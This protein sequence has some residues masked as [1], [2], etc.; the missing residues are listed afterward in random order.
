MGGMMKNRWNVAIAAAVACVLTALLAIASQAAWADELSDLRANQELLQRRV[1]QLAQ[2]T[3]VPATGIGAGGLTSGS[4]PRSFLIPGTDTSL[5]VGGEINLTGVYWFTGG[6]NSNAGGG[7]QILGVPG[8]STAPLNFSIPGVLNP[9]RTR[10]N[11]VFDYSIYA[12][13]LHVE[14]RTPTYLGEAQTVFE[15]DFLGCSLGGFDCNNTVAGQDGLGVRLRLAYATLGQFIAG[16]AWI[17]SI[18]LAA[19]PETIDTGCCA[20]E[21]STGRQPQVAWVQPLQPWGMP[22]ASFGISLASPEDSAMT[23]QGQ[24]LTS[25]TN[26]VT[27]AGTTS[28]TSNAGTVL[29]AGSNQAL[30]IN[31][32][33]T[34]MPD[35]AGN[36]KFVQPWGH[37]QFSGVVHQ[38][39]L[40]DGS[41]LNRQYIGFGGGFSG[42]VKPGWFGWAKDDFG[43]NAF[44]G[45]GLGRY[46]GGGGSGNY[47]PYLETNYGAIG[48]T[49][50]TPSALG[51]ATGNVCGYGHAGVTSTAA[52]ASDI[53]ARLLPEFGAEAW[54]QHWWT[55]TLRSTL[56]FG[57]VHQ[58]PNTRIVG[59][60]TAN[61]GLTSGGVSGGIAQINKEIDAAHINVLW[62]PVP[63]VD[64]GFEYMWSHRVS[65][66]NYRG[67]QQI[68]EYMFKAK[69]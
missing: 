17:Q 1:D 6:N 16:Q 26:L 34:E 14:T 24:T 51:A 19:A 52:C 54:Y 47:F 42:D 49:G 67:D 59:N 15:F 29:N 21:F 57:M 30:S 25:N 11:S 61:G 56:E 39:D 2:A 44:A 22:G 65:I 33:K 18:D 20:G 55:P 13:R 3:A 4:F 35:V 45:Q 64:T 68:A 32:L 9:T 27:A 62:S 31:P 23:P 50:T 58:D 46:A 40:I 36:L 41:F 10:A 37:L 7:T 53:L 8:A 38:A 5:F 12:S 48:P 69:F 43:F 60:L 66:F 28:A 63:F